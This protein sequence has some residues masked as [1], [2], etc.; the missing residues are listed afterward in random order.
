MKFGIAEA[1]ILL[2]SMAMAD[3]VPA[4]SGAAEKGEEAPLQ[5]KAVT[6]SGNRCKRKPV[7]GA[8]YCRQHLKIQE[9]Q[10]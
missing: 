7:R 5:C 1:M 2:V 6:K 8:K 9:K 4:D 3:G 10:K